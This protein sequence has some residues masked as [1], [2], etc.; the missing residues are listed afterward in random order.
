MDDTNEYDEYFAPVKAKTKALNK[1]PAVVANAPVKETAPAVLED[2]NPHDSD[3]TKEGNILPPKPFWTPEKAV[4]A[5]GGVGGALYG[6]ARTPAYSPA[7]TEWAAKHYRVPVEDVAG[8]M[9]MRNPAP[10]TAQEAA[11]AIAARS[12]AIPA[13][14]TTALESVEE[15]PGGH[16]RWLAPR[17]AI[18]VPKAL[19]DQMVTMTGG[20]NTKG[21]GENILAR[22]A[23]GVNKVQEIGYDPFTMEK[24]GSFYIPPEGRTRSQPPQVWN[25]PRAIGPAP[26]TSPEFAT[27]NVPAATVPATPASPL[28]T[29][30]PAASEESLLSK[31]EQNIQRAGGMANVAQRGASAGLAAFGGAMGGLQLLDALRSIRSTGFHPDNSLQA[32]EGAGFVG[33]M[34]Y[35][36]VGLPVAGT[37]KIAR[38][39][40]DI[41]KEGLTPERAAALASGAGLAAM[42]RF[43]VTGLVA[44]TPELYFAL[45]K[46]REEHPAENDYP[47]ELH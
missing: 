31:L 23:A 33:A 20:A 12:S 29:V 34:K 36:K 1:I 4:A 44:Q 26:W 38:A 22:H 3:F 7:F 45:Q 28:S 47:I 21:S 30:T 24:Q 37:A 40:G 11:R 27:P 41:Y 17:S 19:S 15:A 18:P 32:A 43:P 13:T 10:P 2:E 9:N 8:Y 16:A 35:P 25:R 39:A 6:A 42:P 5:V 14:T 46:W